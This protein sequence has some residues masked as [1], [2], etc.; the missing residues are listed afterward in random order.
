MATRPRD[1]KGRFIK[2]QA[3]PAKPTNN[4]NDLEHQILRAYNKMADGGH[5]YDIEDARSEL[6]WMERSLYG[7][8]I[9][10]VVFLLFLLTGCSTKRV[11][12]YVPVETK[13]TETVVVKDTIVQAQLVP[14][15]ETV[16]TPDSTSH[17]EN[18]YAYS[19]ATVSNGILSH[20]L[21]IKPMPV[22]VKAPFI[23]IHHTDSV[24]YP[25]PGPTQY[26]EKELSIIE[27]GLMG[28]GLLTIG[29]A[30]MFGTIKL[31]NLFI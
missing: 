7:L 22:F 10:F 16:Y 13:V 15:K 26:I 31:K 11:V 20:T 24:P 17:L 6:I 29:G 18:D 1:S 28:V 12:E 2:K 30:V 3:E 19:D 8:F 5:E 23:H 21:G 9:I 14:Y 4:E 27:K 25:V